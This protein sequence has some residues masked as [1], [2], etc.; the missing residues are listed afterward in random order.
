M[1]APAVVSLFSGAGGLDLGFMQEGFDL[2]WAN[3]FEADA[4]ETYR[5]NIGNH[6]VLGDISRIPVKEIPGCNVIIGGFPCQGFSQA[7]THKVVDDKRNL[8]YRQYLR[9]LRSKRPE[10]FVAENV[11]G[12]LSLE[13]GTAIKRIVSDFTET[14]YR[15][16]HRLLNAADYGVPQTRQRVIIVGVRSDVE[17]DFSYPEPTH[18]KDG[19]GGLP[20]WM[21]MRDALSEIPDP[22]GADAGT[23]PNNEYSRYKV[24]PRNYTGHRLSDP[25]KPSPTI[26]ARGNG[27]GGVCAI[28]HYSGTRRLSVRESATIQTFPTDFVFHG[29][30][31]SCYRQVGNAV[32]VL[33]ARAVARQVKAVLE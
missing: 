27:G 10:V 3:D 33:L 7:N 24:A 12:I 2:V 23:V 21:S 5:A 16:Q 9:V 17:R 15:V 30:L 4:V 19:R 8:L 26:L 18:A 29:R 22:D 14:G 1:G 25:N 28:P 31:G 6:I 32:P 13:G 11:R 20:A